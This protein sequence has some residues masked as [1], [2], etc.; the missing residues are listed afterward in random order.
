MARAKSLC[1]DAANCRAGNPHQGD[2]PYVNMD[3]AELPADLRDFIRAGGMRRC[4]YCGCLYR[5]ELSGPKI[6][7]SYDDP[8]LG[9]GWHPRSH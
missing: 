7:G 4:G 6:L 5:H 2:F 1:P 8:M 9:Q 3:I